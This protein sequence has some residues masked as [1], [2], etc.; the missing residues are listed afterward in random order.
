[1]DNFGDSTKLSTGTVVRNASVL[2]VFAKQP[3]PGQVK[4]RLTPDLTP[5][6]AATLYAFSLRQTITALSRD[7]DYDVVICYSGEHNYFAERYPQCRL[8]C[9]GQGDLGQRLKRM[10]RQAIQCG[11]QRVCVV[12]TDSPDLPRERVRQA[13]ETL[14]DHDFV[15]VPAEDGGYV[16]AGASDYY[17]SVFEQID[18][19]SE[20]VLEQTR[21]RLISCQLRYRM[22]QSW[23]DIDD[24]NSLRRYVQ[25]Y[26]DNGCARYAQRCLRKP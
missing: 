12:G 20:R 15:L 7:K 23:E 2:L 9:Q 5:C 25:R 14:G 24:V 18:W 21:S 10:F 26:P 16:L 13:F 11:W 6:Q 22:L 1:M 4:T 8:I 17:P 3:L 19:S